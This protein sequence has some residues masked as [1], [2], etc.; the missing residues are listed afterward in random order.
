LVTELSGEKESQIYTRWRID[1]AGISKFCILQ[2]VFE[3]QLAN[4]SGALIPGKDQIRVFG[5]T[6]LKFKNAKKRLN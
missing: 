1:L 2:L 4:V 3:R 5:L 6:S